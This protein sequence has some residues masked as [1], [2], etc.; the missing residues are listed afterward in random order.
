MRGFIEL[1]SLFSLFAFL[2]ARFSRIDLPTF[3]AAL[4]LG[5]FPDIGITPFYALPYPIPYPL[6]FF[7][8]V[9][10]KPGQRRPGAARAVTK[11]LTNRVM[12][13]FFIVTARGFFYLFGQAD[14]HKTKMPIS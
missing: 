11:S 9:P 6:L 2:S 1:I 14:L 12:S 5:D 10:K 8:P 4:L 13:T 7:M 3:L